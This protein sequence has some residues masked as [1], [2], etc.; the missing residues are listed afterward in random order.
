MEMEIQENDELKETEKVVRR[1]S[2]RKMFL[3]IL[4]NF[5]ENTCVRVLQLY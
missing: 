3:K 5:Q 2:V 1:C 4:K